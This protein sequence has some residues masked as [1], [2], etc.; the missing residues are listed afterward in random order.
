MNDINFTIKPKEYYVAK[1]N[2]N[3]PE[4]LSEIV[5]PTGF[6]SV[7]EDKNALFGIGVQNIEPLKHFGGGDSIV[8]DFGNHYVGNF[9]F[10]V[11]ISFSVVISF[12]I[13]TYLF[14]SREDNACEHCK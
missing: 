5:M 8:V 3:T 11:S 13:K 7:I 1:A 9:S 6:A 14:F 2:E 10:K 12:I 4:I